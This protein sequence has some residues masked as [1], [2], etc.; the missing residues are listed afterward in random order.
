MICYSC[1]KS[2]LWT[3]LGVF[4][5]LVKDWS[6]VGPLFPELLK[7]ARLLILLRLLKYALS[8]I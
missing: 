1:V 4:L 2:L 3:V 6:V 7:F 5:F 8:Y